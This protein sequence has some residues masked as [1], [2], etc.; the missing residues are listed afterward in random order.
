MMKVMA[1]ACGHDH[2]KSF[3]LDDIATWNRETSDPV[4]IDY[5]GVRNS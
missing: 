3:N 4:G 5:A 2:L 1:R